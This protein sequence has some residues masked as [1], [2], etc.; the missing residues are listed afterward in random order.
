MRCDCR[1]NSNHKLCV[2]VPHWYPAFVWH[3]HCSQFGAQFGGRR[4]MIGTSDYLSLLLSLNYTKIIFLNNKV[5]Q[6]IHYFTCAVYL[7]HM[8]CHLRNSENIF[9]DACSPWW[10]WCLSFN[11]QHVP[12]HPLLFCLRGAPLVPGSY[13]LLSLYTKQL[14]LM[15]T[16]FKDAMNAHGWVMLP[17]VERSKWTMKLANGTEEYFMPTGSKNSSNFFLYAIWS[18]FHFKVILIAKFSFAIFITAKQITFEKQK[19]NQARF[20]SLG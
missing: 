20:L 13:C 16:R 3:P 7:F 5:F 17:L 11:H 12:F 8:D 15:N 1:Y 19:E 18:L 9:E 10:L 14:K 4:N 6:N 2:L